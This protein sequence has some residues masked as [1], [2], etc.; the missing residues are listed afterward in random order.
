MSL[1]TSLHLQDNTKL[2]THVFTYEDSETPALGSVE[3]EGGLRIVAKTPT[4]LLVL[5]EALTDTARRL[6]D[7]LDRAAA[8]A[9]NAAAVPA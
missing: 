1:T 3:V 7:E 9:I 6:S 5:A 2:D 4:Q 8:R